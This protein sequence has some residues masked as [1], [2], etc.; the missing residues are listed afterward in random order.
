[1]TRTAATQNIPT[2]VSPR[3]N[4]THLGVDVVPDWFVVVQPCEFG[5]GQRPD[6]TLQTQLLSRS[7]HHV[8][9]RG[10]EPGGLRGRPGCGGG[11]ETWLNFDHK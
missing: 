5:V 6:G 2:P 1:M 11:D 8:T 4:M 10:G 9:Q 3:T 7:G